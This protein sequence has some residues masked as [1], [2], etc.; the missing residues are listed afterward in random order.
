M[1][2]S[3]FLYALSVSTTVKAKMTTT[4]SPRHRVVILGGGLAGCTAAWDL[5][6]S[7]GDNISLTI[8]EA[9]N[10]LGGRIHTIDLSGDGGSVPDSKLEMGANWIHGTSP[11]PLYAFLK[12]KKLMIRA[13]EIEGEWIGITDQGE[14]IP[15]SLEARAEKAA[16]QLEEARVSFF[17]EE[18]KP[19]GVDADDDAG[20]FTQRYFKRNFF[21]KATSDVERSM[22]E[23]YARYANLVECNSWGCDNLNQVSLA[24]YGSFFESS[25]DD[26]P[27]KNGFGSLIEFLAESFKEDEV[28]LNSTVDTI[29]WDDREDG[30]KEIRVIL[31]NGLVIIADYLLVT[32][33]AGCLKARQPKF[34]PQL[35]TK[36][37]KAIDSVGYGVVNKI[38]VQL[39]ASQRKTLVDAVGDGTVGVYF[40][41]SADVDVDNLTES[42]V[43]GLDGL[44]FVRRDLILLWL[45]GPEARYVEGLEDDVVADALDRVFSR[46]LGTDVGAFRHPKKLIRTGWNANQFT[47]GSYSFPAKGAP[48]GDFDAIAEPIMLKYNGTT[49][50]KI[51]FA[52]E[53]THLTYYS[54]T[55]GAFE[56]GKR[57]AKRL[58][59]HLGFNGAA[60]LRHSFRAFS[61]FS[62]I[63]LLV[64]MVF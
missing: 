12:E 8:V 1:I 13:D 9:E 63:A 41:W 20:K 29:V 56:S 32:V 49:A 48:I 22:M 18:K 36:K 28:L 54:T 30:D 19:T 15:D 16:A 23:A 47:R 50:P 4:E 40:L 51:M 64:I 37:Q 27:L 62:M 17:V 24:N 35:P 39:D 61:L 5:K 58:R 45:H 6:Q 38:F 34:Q 10:R 7:I 60:N 55:H 33:S 3:L 53:A 46:I 2:F 31:K 11:N 43:R 44:Q 21:D 14:D 26:I 52:G 59:K 42:W 25:G 57:E